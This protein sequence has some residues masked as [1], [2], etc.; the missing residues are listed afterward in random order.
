M[1]TPGAGPPKIPDWHVLAK[2]VRKETQLGGGNGGLEWVYVVP[3]VIDS[4]PAKG[5]THH[6]TVDASDYTPASV[7][8]AI[9]DDAATHEGVGN[10]G[11][12]N[13][14]MA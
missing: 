3:Y 1:T 10:L 2:Q 11:R 5:A 13:V 7:Q 4:G 6:V 14:A 12:G 9:D 8:A